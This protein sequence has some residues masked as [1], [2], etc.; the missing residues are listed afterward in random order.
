GVSN[1][2]PGAP[3]AAG[4]GSVLCVP[5]ASAIPAP[6]VVQQ[7]K[8]RTRFASVTDGTSNTIV[9]GEKHVQL[10]F[11]G[12]G[13]QGDTALYNADR[14]DPTLRVASA[15]RPLARSVTEGYNR[16]FGSAHPG[17]VQFA[18]C[19]GTVRPISTATSGAILGLLAQRN[20]GNPIPD[21]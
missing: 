16:Q 3:D 9:I 8:P 6:C 5:R 14:P 21:F 12:Q 15:V 11:F 17:I 4:D 20:D 7:W 10:G 2:N 18:F 1:P 19:D 13:S